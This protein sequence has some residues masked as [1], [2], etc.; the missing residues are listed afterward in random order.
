VR[1]PRMEFWRKAQYLFVVFGLRLAKSK[2][3]ARTGRGGNIAAG[4]AAYAAPWRAIAQ[5]V[6][7]P[8]T[9]ACTVRAQRGTGLH[10]RGPPADRARLRGSGQVDQEM[11]AQ[12]LES[13]RAI[14]P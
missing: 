2:N 7:H 9:G 13:E 10:Q 3:R 6:A 4:S 1:R 8:C 12:R 11:I 5:P 14:E